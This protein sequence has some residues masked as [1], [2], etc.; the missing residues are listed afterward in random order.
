[1]NHL[2]AIHL[3]DRVLNTRD[4]QIER[5][6]VR[7]GEQVE[8]EGTQG[9]E[10]FGRRQK[11]SPFLDGLAF[12][13][14]R[15]L[16]IGQH[17]VA[18]QQP[19]NRRHGRGRRE[20]NHHIQRVGNLFDGADRGYALNLVIVGVDDVNRTLECAAAEAADD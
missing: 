3:S 17:H 1:M 13:R 7:R 11:T 5:M 2:A 4:F 14:D 9:I 16:E 15:S 12:F 6:I 19:L 20:D 8:A 18:L 10:R